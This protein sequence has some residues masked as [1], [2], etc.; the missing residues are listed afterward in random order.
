MAKKETMKT[1][2]VEAEKVADAA[3]QVALKKVRGIVVVGTFNKKKGSIEFAGVTTN[4]VTDK[5]FVTL[6]HACAEASGLSQE[7]LRS[8]LSRELSQIF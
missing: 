6:L 3:K 5:E 1:N 7:L 8:I 2:D 4:K